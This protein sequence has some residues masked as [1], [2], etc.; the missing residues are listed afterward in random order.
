[1]EGAAHEGGKG[2][3]IWDAY[4]REPGAILDS[5]T[6]RTSTSPATTITASTRTSPS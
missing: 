3:S 2:H 4:A 6:P 5:S 1:M